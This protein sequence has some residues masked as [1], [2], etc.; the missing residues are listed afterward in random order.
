VKT[1]FDTLVACG[2]EPILLDRRLLILPHGGRVLGLAPDGRTN[3]IW[4]N[5]AL[6]AADS[7][8]AL[9]ADAGWVNLGGDRTWISPELD[10]QITDPLDC[11]N[12]YTVPKSVD[13]AAYTVTAQDERSVT[14]E[15][16]MQVYFRRAS[17]NLRLRVRKEI[18]LLDTPPIDLAEGTDSVG[19]RQTCTLT[20]EPSPGCAARP[21]LWQVLQVPGGGSIQIPVR[22][23]ARPRA[24][25]GKPVYEWNGQR[26]CCEV[27]TDA[28]FKFSLVAAD[29]LGKLMYLSQI[30][31]RD[32]I[33]MRSLPVH[34]AS[35]YA[36]VSCADPNDIGHVQQVYVDDG[37]FGGFGELE[38]HSP[39]VDA[40]NGGSVEECSE[41]WACI[42][43]D[44]NATIESLLA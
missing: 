11:S 18:A 28:S 8:R 37:A 35:L 2:Q 23:G 14:L 42:G 41:V 43:E 33:V 15:S 10:T 19:Y 4:T 5:P 32:A 13:P 31:G 1:I 29:C 17:A 9:L 40:A 39:A 22:A 30:N 44:L 34:D 6:T 21:G 20:V 27:R 38:Y 16:Y 26:L 3:L 7:A 25:I 12:G 24:F 36:D